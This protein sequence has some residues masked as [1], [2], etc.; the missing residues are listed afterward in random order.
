MLGLLEQS[1]AVPWDRCLAHLSQNWDS[2][3]KAAAAAYSVSGF[4]VLDSI[5]VLARNFEYKIS[6][7]D[8][9]FTGKF[10]VKLLL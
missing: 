7:S 6:L 5:F 10:N 9:V 4:R 1:H 8:S 2:I 3:F